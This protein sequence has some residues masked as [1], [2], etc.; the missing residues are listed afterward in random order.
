MTARATPLGGDAFASRCPD[1]PDFAARS[2]GQ[3][4]TTAILARHDKRFHPLTYEPA[5]HS[6]SVRD[7]PATIHP[8]LADGAL[9][10]F[11]TTARRSREID[12][13]GRVAVPTIRT[14]TKEMSN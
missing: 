2:V 4:D 5:R 11:D 8:V 1:C 13:D 12:G 6:G 14:N 9:P 7:L 3:S 10:T